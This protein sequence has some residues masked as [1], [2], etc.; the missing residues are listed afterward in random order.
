MKQST[1]GAVFCQ[2]GGDELKHDIKLLD[3]TSAVKDALMEKHS[4]VVLNEL[5]NQ[6]VDFYTQYYPDRVSTSKDYKLIGNMTPRKYQ[7]IAYYGAHPWSAFTHALS[8]KMRAMRYCNV[9]DYLSV[10]EM[11][12][13]RRLKQKQ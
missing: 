10:M 7:S 1:C 5:I 11:L 4:A 8:S 9:K 2:P 6:T 3:F 12:C 13:I